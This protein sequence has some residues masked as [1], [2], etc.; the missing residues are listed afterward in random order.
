MV[1]G[2]EVKVPAKAKDR[3]LAFVG[4]G[5]IAIADVSALEYFTALTTEALGKTMHPHFA[6]NLRDKEGTCWAME[7]MGENVLGV[8]QPAQQVQLLPTGVLYDFPGL[9]ALLSVQTGISC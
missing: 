4:R 2:E 3:A 7:H 1:N 9:R 8:A 6:L 5:T